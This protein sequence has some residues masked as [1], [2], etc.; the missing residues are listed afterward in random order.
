MVP[1][2]ENITLEPGDLSML[3]A[4]FDDAWA[5]LHPDYAQA[6]EPVVAQA[7][8][9]L[10]RIMFDLMKLHQL[11]GEQLKQTSVRL[12]RQASKYAEA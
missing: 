1:H 10:A 11:D 8:T 3:G 5:G 2:P 12:F 7:R 9:Q 6:E 4:A